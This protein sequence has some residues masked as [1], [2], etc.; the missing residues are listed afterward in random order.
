MLLA[1][2]FTMRRLLRN[3]CMVDHVMWVVEVRVL[4]F[5]YICDQSG[6]IT[7]TPGWGK[8][9]PKWDQVSFTVLPKAEQT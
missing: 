3:L 6:R 8:A 7:E 5:G 9:I 2:M 4:H 1:K